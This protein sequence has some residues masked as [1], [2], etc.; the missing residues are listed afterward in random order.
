MWVIKI[1]LNK[2]LMISLDM[3]ERNQNEK[4]RNGG[5]SMMDLVVSSKF[6][7][8]EIRLNNKAIMF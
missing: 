7:L 4:L 5:K 8:N 1:N 6:T 3:R 2:T